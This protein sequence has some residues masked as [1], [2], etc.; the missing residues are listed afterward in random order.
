[1]YRYTGVQLK[2]KAMI[3]DRIGKHSATPNL[4]QRIISF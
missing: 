3:T 4:T 1:M 2:D